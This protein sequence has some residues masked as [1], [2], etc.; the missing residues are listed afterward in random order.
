MTRT[1]EE[2]IRTAVPQ[3]Q[4]LASYPT[5]NGSGNPNSFLAKIETASK[6]KDL[7]KLEILEEPY[8]SFP[9]PTPRTAPKRY[10]N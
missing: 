6:I 7:R 2:A 1:L 10:I 8:L 3:E 5:F 4:R 9:P